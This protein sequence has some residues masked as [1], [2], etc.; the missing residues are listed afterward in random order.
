MVSNTD[1]IEAGPDATKSP[2]KDCYEEEDNQF[3]DIG[4]PNDDDEGNN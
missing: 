3:E 4:L 2:L 1:D